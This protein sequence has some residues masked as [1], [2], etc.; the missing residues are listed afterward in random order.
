MAIAQELK[1]EERRRKERVAQSK[2]AQEM[3][4]PLGL[5]LHDMRGM[6]CFVEKVCETPEFIALLEHRLMCRVMDRDEA[7]MIITPDPASLGQRSQLAALINGAWI[8]CPL[9]VKELKGPCLKYK[10]ASATERHILLTED[11]QSKHGSV[12]HALRVAAALPGSAWTLY[13]D[14]ERFNHKFAL[15]RARNRTTYWIALVRKGKVPQ[16]LDGNVRKLSVDAFMQFITKIDK[17]RS[18]TI[19]GQVAE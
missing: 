9:Y 4:S 19:M 10:R 16:D 12:C 6:K 18:R 17:A 8:C 2:R 11:F 14:I 7:E 5:T 3:A 1:N 15:A 13:V